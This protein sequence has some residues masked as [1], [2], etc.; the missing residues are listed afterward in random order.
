LPRWN[1]SRKSNGP[2]ACVPRDPV[3]QGEKFDP[4]G[5]YV[6][7]W[8]P[9]IAKLTNEWVH[10]PWEAPLEVVS[11]AGLELGRTYPQPIVSHTIAREVALETFAKTRSSKPARRVVGWRRE[12]V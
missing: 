3:N 1:W 6:R 11:R 12:D 5:A 8:C 10:K 4:L 2:E 7:R 9:E